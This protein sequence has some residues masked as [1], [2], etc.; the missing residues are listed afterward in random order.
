MVKYTYDSWG[1]PLSCTGTLATTLGALNPFRYRGYVYDEETGFYYLKSRYYDPETCRFIPADV[2]LST[3]QGIL[4]HN[5]YAYCGSNSV[6]RIDWG[7]NSWAL[8]ALALVL[9]VIA[10]ATGCKK[11]GSDAIP[12]PDDNPEKVDAFEYN[13]SEKNSKE[14]QQFR[15]EF[16]LI[17]IANYAQYD[18]GLNNEVWNYRG[19]ME[20]AAIRIK[21]GGQIAQN[22]FAN[23]AKNYGYDKLASNL[24]Q[25]GVEKYNA[26]FEE[27][28]HQN[29]DAAVIASRIY[30]TLRSGM[31]SYEKSLR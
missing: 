19:P 23:Y 28:Y 17:V 20:P 30:D 6:N 1:K 14:F 29:Y 27:K 22:K 4:G 13:P 21:Y 8:I 15:E 10:T 18:A 5:C 25:L 26:V 16:G 24:A 7:G 2:L 3:G 11:K 9:G 12:E 31:V